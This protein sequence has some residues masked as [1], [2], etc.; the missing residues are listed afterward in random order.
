MVGWALPTYSFG[1]VAF[2]ENRKLKTENPGTEWATPF[3][4]LLPTSPQKQKKS[5][6]AS[7]GTPFTIRR[8]LILTARQVF[9]LSDQPKESQPSHRGF[10]IPG[11]GRLAPLTLLRPRLQRRDRPG[12]APG[13]GLPGDSSI[14]LII[15]TQP[16][17]CQENPNLMHLA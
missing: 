14:G 8:S 10:V 5:P 1:F 15:N 16:R 13:S 12:F 7:D 4:S 3:N 17:L 9:W 6:I 11:S 2:T